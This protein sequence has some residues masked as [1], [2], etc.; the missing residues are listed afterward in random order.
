MNVKSLKQKNDDLLNT[1]KSATTADLKKEIKQK[2]IITFF[3]TE[4]L[5]LKITD[6]NQNVTDLQCAWYIHQSF[7]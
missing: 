2:I 4:V 1:Y 3:I 6:M 7:S 5:N